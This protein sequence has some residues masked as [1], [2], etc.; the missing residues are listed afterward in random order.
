MEEDRA[1]TNL[2]PEPHPSSLTAEVD[3]TP[4]QPKRRVIGQREAT[5]RAAAKASSQKDANGEKNIEDGGASLTAPRQTRTPRTLHQIPPEILNDPD[6]KLAI[7]HLPSNY[8]FEIPKTIHRMRTLHATSVA[9]QF[10]EGLLM[11]APLI[12]DIL[13]Q[14]CPGTEM[15]IM[16]DVTYGACCVD[17][18][19]ARALGC[20]LL[21]H[22]GH[23]C[24]VPVDQTGKNGIKTLYVFVTI[25]VDTDH[26]LK[27]VERNFM[28][29][30][31]I[32]LVGTIQFNPTLHAI[33]PRLREMGYDPIM[34]RSA[35]LSAGE[36]LGCTA[37]TLSSSSSGSN[38]SSNA[39]PAPARRETAKPKSNGRDQ[40]HA[41]L[42]LYVGDGRFHLESIMIASPDLRN[43]TYRY[44]PY[45]RRLTH[46]TYEHTD[47][48]AL[49]RAAILEARRSIQKPTYTPSNPPTPVSNH[50]TTSNLPT[51]SNTPP[52]PEEP[53]LWCLI[54]GTLG[55]QGNPHTT[56]LLSTHLTRLNIP[57]ITLLLSEITPQK[58]G[59]MQ[60]D[61]AVW[62]QVA[63]P[64]LSVDWG[65]AFGRPLLTAR[66]GLW[67]LGVGGD[68]RKVEG[69]G[70]WDRV[71]DGD[72]AVPEW[73][74]E[75]E[76]DENETGTTLGAG[77]EGKGK[78]KESVEGG[79]EEVGLY[80]MDY[81][82]KDGLGR[83]KAEDVP[84]PTL[85]PEPGTAAGMEVEVK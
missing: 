63:C 18:Y 19:T 36:I 38:A 66:E 1:Q 56:S 46:E 21:V 47:M 72:A 7:S 54:L 6:L 4:K 67:A 59:D 49:R 84:V 42:I 60:R 71:V 11:F 39:H 57:H 44:D 31:R 77:K 55:R 68:G 78:R 30:K 45:T 25:G 2:A 22:Y 29:G 83:V 79:G 50:H 20:D 9:L 80:P 74:K 43:R 33:V 75:D 24:L 73:L 51:P 61:V 48:H 5:I 65:Y 82:A 40:A 34:P 52:Q 12:S 32:A 76:D 85:L 16:G 53:T 14:F 81:Y 23:S 28:T 27:T 62:V 13:A 41:D 26:L 37:P 10:P 15:L 69:E 58:L 35:P 70:G 64:R 8:N 3:A 17:D